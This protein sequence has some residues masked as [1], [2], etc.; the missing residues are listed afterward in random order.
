MNKNKI[1]QRRPPIP[2]SIAVGAREVAPRILA[3]VQNEYQHV[4]STM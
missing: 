3:I 4:T 1:A 2:F